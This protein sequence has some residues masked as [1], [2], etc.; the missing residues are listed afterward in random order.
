LELGMGRLDEMFEFGDTLALAFDL[1]DRGVP[2]VSADDVPRCAIAG[3]DAA[4]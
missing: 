3:C 2:C 1:D 4:C